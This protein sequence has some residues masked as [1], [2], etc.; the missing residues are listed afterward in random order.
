MFKPLRLP[1]L[2]FL[3]CA[4]NSVLAA[5]S[6]QY[7]CATRTAIQCISSGECAD[8]LPETFHL[9]GFLRLDLKQK[10]ITAGE[11][12]SSIDSLTELETGYAMHGKIPGVHRAW[13][14]TY[15]HETG[16]MTATITGVG[17]GYVV[18][19]ICTPVKY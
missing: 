16:W 19:G 17:E 13:S 2:L 1:S 15:E 5:Q 10:T 4:S 18:F 9:P 7:L 6:N 12:K 8:G 14:L 11:L 3:V